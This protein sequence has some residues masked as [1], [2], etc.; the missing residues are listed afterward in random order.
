MKIKYSIPPAAAPICPKDLWNGLAGMFSGKN[1]ICRLEEEIKEHFGSRHVFL[2]SSGKAALTLILT[3]LK[4]VSP[5]RM[6][7]LIPA[8]TCFSVPS[9]IVKAGLKV[10][11]C[12]IDLSTLDFDYKLLEGTVNENTL[13]VV[14]NHLFGV[15]SNMDMINGICKARGT[16]V[17]EDAAQAMGGRYNGKM[18]GT[19]GDAGFFSLGR[20]KNVTSGGGGIII[21]NSDEIGGAIGREYSRLYSPRVTE[22]LKELLRS[23]ALSLFI[24][25]SLYWFPSG[26]PLLRLGETIFYRDFPVKKL[27]G[28]KAG[29][30]KG[31]RKRLQDSNRIHEENSAY[32]LKMLKSM[33]GKDSSIPYIRLPIVM[34]NK[35]SKDMIFTASN[36]LGLGISKMYP[37]PV[38]E[39]DEIKNQFNGHA[40][41]SAKKV[42]ERLITIPTHHLLTE[43]SKKEIGELLAECIQK[44]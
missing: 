36:E 25:P 7:V 27:S 18:L 6:E 42:A 11:L 15:P 43:R 8:Y 12:D 19:I 44:S 33:T 23:V 41:P 21:T 4:T 39:I 9:A 32:F 38:N 29:L 16:F 13:C 10:S 5:G 3:A 31:W 17:V 37:T 24:R 35:E 2:V 14:P 34:K 20:G 22:D 26:L 40:Y 1:N 30:L 28:M